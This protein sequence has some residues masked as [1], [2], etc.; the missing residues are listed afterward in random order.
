MADEKKISALTS[1]E[2]DNNVMLVKCGVEL[3]L[4]V[5]GSMKMVA[6]SAFFKTHNEN[7][8]KVAAYILR[9][10]CKD[11]N[12]DDLDDSALDDLVGN[13]HYAD[14]ATII[15]AFMDVDLGDEETANTLKEVFREKERAERSQK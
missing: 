1:F 13:M 3:K 8:L 2:K 4:E 14:I 6:A 10:H 9:H 5:P 7:D 11:P 12:F 15:L